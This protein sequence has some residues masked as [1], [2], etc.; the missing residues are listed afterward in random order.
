[1]KLENITLRNCTFAFRCNA[2]WGTM[3]K[4]DSDGRIKF[5]S[6]CQKQVYLCETDDELIDHVVNNHCVAIIKTIDLEEY[7]SLGDINYSK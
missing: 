2:N 3:I 4:T 1:M 7:R 6:D 5:C